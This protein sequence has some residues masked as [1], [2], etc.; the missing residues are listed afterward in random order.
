VFVVM[1]K[2]AAFVPLTAKPLNARRAPAELLRVTVWGALATPITIDPKLSVDGVTVKGPAIPVPDN[3]R[4]WGELLAVS[5]KVRVADRALM[6]EGVSTTETLQLAPLARFNGQVFVVMR[7]SAAF[8]PP[9]AKPLNAMLA[10]AEL[11]RVTV[12]GALA[13]PITI[14]PKLRADGVT[15]KGPTPVP[16]NDKD[17]GES[18]A[19]SAISRDA[20]LTPGA[21]GANA[22][23]RVQLAEAPR[24]D[25]HVDETNGKSAPLSPLK[26]IP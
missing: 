5:V 14:D 11:L 2:S 9:T 17:C 21:D 23:D 4:D 18:P 25:P 8:V 26:A 13:I 7:K 1:R 15:V 20:V 24:D 16:D 3:E 6:A 10:P 19:E 12:W 22:S